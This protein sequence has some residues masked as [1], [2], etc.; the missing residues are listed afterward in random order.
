MNKAFDIVSCDENKES[1]RKL[2]KLIEDGEGVLFVGSGSSVRLKYPSW[3]DILRNL[4]EKITEDAV[5]KIIED[6]ISKGELLLA[7]EII[8][9]KIDATEYKTH[10]RA[11]LDQKIQLIMLFTNY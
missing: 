11:F 3:E 4:T 8:K 5:K 6:K 2:F 10:L 9:C 1:Q 7:A